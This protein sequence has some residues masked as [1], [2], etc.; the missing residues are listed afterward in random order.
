M[1]SNNHMSSQTANLQASVAASQEASEGC[2]PNKAETLT[3]DNDDSDD[4]HHVG[5]VMGI[6]FKVWSLVK[7]EYR[8]DSCFVYSL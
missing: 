8:C 3:G 6:F 1:V 2:N 7:G 4:K 5:P